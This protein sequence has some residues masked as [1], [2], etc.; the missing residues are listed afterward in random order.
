MNLILNYSSLFSAILILLSFTSLLAQQIQ[1]D[2]YDQEFFELDR[3]A[4]TNNLSGK[5]YSVFN[6]FSSNNIDSIF[7]QTNFSK[8]SN[9][10]IRLFETCYSKTNF[11]NISEKIL[12]YYK[13]NVKSNLVSE[14]KNKLLY[15]NKAVF[16]N[17]NNNDFKIFFNPILNLSFG[18][19]INNEAIIFQ[20]S[21]GLDI[22]GEIESKI[23][24]RSIII[25]NQQGFLNFENERILKTQSILGQGS[26]KPYQSSLNKKI[27]GYDFFYVKSY[28]KFNIIKPISFEFGHGNFFLVME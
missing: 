21:R 16:F 12:R 4:K 13:E 22:V 17:V 7:N 1:F 11:S 2:R 8:L 18:R 23:Q 15:K 28:V 10:E 24:F 14:R 5:Y 6:S 20:N 26:Q 27:T 19:Q 25:E 9:D 3:L